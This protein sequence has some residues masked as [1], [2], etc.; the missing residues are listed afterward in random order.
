[1][2]TAMR[3]IDL[4]CNWLCQYAAETTIFDPTLYADVQPRLRR[5]SGYLQGTALTLLYCG[6]KAPEW[7]RRDDRWQALAELLALSE[8][9]FSGRLLIGPDDVARWRAEPADG[10]CWGMLAVGGFDF[11]VGEPADVD[12]LSALFERG[13]RVFQLVDGLTSTLAGSA[14]PGDDR[15]LTDLGRAF[16]GR[17]GELD[18][19][20]A[21]RS[22]PIVDLALLNP[23]SLGE[24]LD[25]VES[26]S[27]SVGRPLLICS[28]GGV[29][30]SDFEI[31]GAWRHEDVVR[32]R[33]LGG[34]IALTPS[35]SF[36]RTPDDLKSAI[37]ALAA[38]PFEGRSGYEGIAIGTDFTGL[39][40]VM[41]GLAEVGEITNW[42]GRSFDRETA[43]RL[44]AGNASRLLVRAAGFPLAD[45]AIG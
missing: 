17:L 4:H 23:R 20:H 31:A 39:E 44:A 21:P 37:E 38:I 19:S 3:L 24:V 36:F 9:E 5:L 15:G 30:Q 28:H 18:V 1:M 2:V 10:L 13:V 41:P 45:I 43:G 42:I 7:E 33:A 35:P 27:G 34:V 6:R 16:L 11:L 14:E 8:A 25:W 22:R 40:Q 32:L 29:S 12:R 26:Q